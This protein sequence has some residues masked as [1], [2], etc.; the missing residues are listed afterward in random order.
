MSIE[1]IQTSEVCKTETS[2]DGKP[3]SPTEDYE[4]WPKNGENC[5]KMITQALLNLK[6]SFPNVESVDIVLWDLNKA[7]FYVSDWKEAI[8]ALQSGWKGLRVFIDLYVFDYYDENAGDGEFNY[9]QGWDQQ[10]KEQKDVYFTVTNLKWKEPAKDDEHYHGQ[11]MDPAAWELL[12]DEDPPSES[13][14]ENA[15]NLYSTTVRPM[16]VTC[17]TD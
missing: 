2:A 17:L 4:F 6:S 15:L 7:A 12:D 1:I 3:S 16:Y 8:A 14:F 10:Y 11:V 13:V 5:A 9:S